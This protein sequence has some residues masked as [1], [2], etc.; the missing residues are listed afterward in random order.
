MMDTIDT[1]TKK[2]NEIVNPIEDMAV[3][4]KH[5]LEKLLEPLNLQEESLNEVI[6]SVL[7]TNSNINNG[8]VGNI[9]FTPSSDFNIINGPD[10]E[11]YFVDSTGLFINVKDVSEDTFIPN[12][13]SSDIVEIVFNTKVDHDK[14]GINVSWNDDK[15]KIIA[16]VNVP[17]GIEIKSVNK[18]HIF[19]YFT[20]LEIDNF[21]LKAACSIEYITN[22]TPTCIFYTAKGDVENV[23]PSAY[24]KF[25]QPSKVSSICSNELIIKDAGAVNPRCL[26]E[27]NLGQSVN[28][29]HYA[30]SKWET[31]FTSQ[32]DLIAI[33]SK[34]YGVG[35]IRWRAIEIETQ[36]EI[37][38]V[39]NTENSQE[40]F[41]DLLD[42]I[43]IVGELIP[44]QGNKLSPLPQEKVY[45]QHVTNA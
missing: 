41:R 20:L 29:K 39:S 43:D 5:S 4:L 44:S 31:E 25:S 11:Q 32:D 38:I 2:Q 8:P 33:Q 40:A 14:S 22:D 15:T 17:E 3:S 9:Q 36:E 45:T 18:K 16:T 26:Y 23:K 1:F 28:C 30:G 34:R 42:Q 27:S 19:E 7:P 24:Y 6:M 35:R 37:M 21:L 10:G 12:H 13:Q